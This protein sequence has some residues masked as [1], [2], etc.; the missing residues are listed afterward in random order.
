MN[1]S[2]VYVTTTNPDE[3]GRIGEV[4]VAEKL[5]ASVNV[6]GEVRSIF[7]WEGEIHDKIET[8]LLAKTSTQRVSVVIE[9]I[10][11]LH[12]YQCP[13]IVTWCLDRGNDA[14]LNWIGRETTE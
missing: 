10:H 7:H 5:V 8:A 13:C 14:Y 11:A 9:R 12:S 1:V 6:L 4:L 2:L 3:A